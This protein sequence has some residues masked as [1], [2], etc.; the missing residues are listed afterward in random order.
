MQLISKSDRH[1]FKDF[2][3][4]GTYAI[5]TEKFLNENTELKSDKIKISELLNLSRNDILTVNS[6]YQR[7]AVWGRSS[8]KKAYR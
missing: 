8:T 1:Q 3:A 6:E 7:G 5:V 4:F 2:E